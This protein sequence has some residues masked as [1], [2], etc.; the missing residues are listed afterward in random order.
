MDWLMQDTANREKAISSSLISND[1]VELIIQYL[2]DLTDEGATTRDVS[3]YCDISVYSARHWLIK[4]EEQDM[5]HSVKHGGRVS[6]W[7]ITI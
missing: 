2:S 1:N 5:V 6:K 4:M 7:Y 3:Y